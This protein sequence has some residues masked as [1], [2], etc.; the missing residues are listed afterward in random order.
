MNYQKQILK[1]SEEEDEILILSPLMKYYLKHLPL[2][3]EMN[4]LQTKEMIEEYN[5]DK[6]IEIKRDSDDYSHLSNDEL[7]DEIINDLEKEIK[8]LYSLF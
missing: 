1:T 2:L 8:I 3:I 4:N 7:K 6:E 5:L